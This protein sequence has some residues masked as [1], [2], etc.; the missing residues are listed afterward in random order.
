MQSMIQTGILCPF[1]LQR[2]AKYLIQQYVLC[3]KNDFE[4]EKR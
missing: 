1:G 3:Q 4:D 2:Y